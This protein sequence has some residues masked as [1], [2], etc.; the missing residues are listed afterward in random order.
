MVS[1][2]ENILGL[3]VG[4]DDITMIVN[5]PLMRYATVVGIRNESPDRH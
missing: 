1:S 5:R 2:V 4:K 3:V